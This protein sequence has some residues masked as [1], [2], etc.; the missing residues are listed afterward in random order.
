MG[1]SLRVVTSFAVLAAVLVA[2]SANL[3]SAAPERGTLAQLDLTAGDRAAG[4]DTFSSLC[5]SCHS[6]GRLAFFAPEDPERL[7]QLE[8]AI[9]TGNE[10]MPAYLPDLMTEQTLIDVL[11]YITTPEG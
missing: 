4:R 9:R 1:K 8:F 6:A 7:P 11:A 2:L 10:D 3:A 5:E